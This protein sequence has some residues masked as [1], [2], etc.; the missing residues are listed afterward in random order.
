[1]YCSNCAENQ[2]PRIGNLALLFGESTQTYYALNV[3]KDNLVSEYGFTPHLIY[4]PKIILVENKQV[5]SFDQVCCMNGCGVDII[6]NPHNNFYNYSFEVIKKQAFSIE[7]FLGL[8][9][10]KDY[11]YYVYPK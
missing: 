8:L 11:D 3:K 6:F 9:N 10:H 7:R 5:I 2:M 1:M 4:N